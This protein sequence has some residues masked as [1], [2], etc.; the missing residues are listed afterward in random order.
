MSD[1]RVLICGGGIAAIEG[2]LRLRTLLGDAAS[3][4][5]MAP[6]QDLVLRP[7]AVR[8][9]FAGG[10]APTYPL[11]GIAEDCGATW[12]QDSLAW[13]ERSA[14]IAHTRSGEKVR[15]D[16]LLV[17][18]GAP[19]A[20]PFEHVR[21]FSD[22]HADEIYHGVVQD[23][24]GAYVSSM[25]F[26]L[27]VGPTWPLPIYEIA[28]MTAERALSMG[29]PRL[30]LTLV[31]S[32]ARPLGIF[33]ERASV[34]ISERLDDAGVTVYASALAHVSGPQSLLIQPQGTE[35]HP[36]RI[37]AMPRVVGPEI[38]GLPGSGSQ[39]FIPID[40]HCCV[41][42][43]DGRIY[44]AGDATAYPIKHGALG[45]QMADTAAVGIARLAGMDLEPVDFHPVIYG[46]V[47]TGARPL[48]IS[49]RLVGTSGFES[50]VHDTPPW[51]A[52]DKVVAEELGPYLA[53]LDVEAASSA[54]GS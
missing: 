23:V 9:P 2:L 1:F 51:P 47:L 46:T 21:T 38:R 28:L 41:P 3:I 5:L 52:G 35:L 20:E 19:Q 11:R 22:R 15:Y 39:G 42:G 10:P 44:A 34:A 40:R 6:D 48:Y 54:A 49:S 8:Q 30:D 43:T 7:L 25:A 17:A 18:V 27:P 26:I 16:A 14:K 13:V 32:E 45:A 12:R 50:E 31:T 36:D 29:V 24:E 33:G 37:L 4:E 53:G